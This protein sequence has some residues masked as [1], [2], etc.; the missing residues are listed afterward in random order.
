MVLPEI[1]PDDVVLEFC[2]PVVGVSGCAIG[3]VATAPAVLSDRVPEVVPGV[4]VD[5]ELPLRVV[6]RLPEVVPD[7]EPLMVSAPLVVPL[8][9]DRSV[10]ALC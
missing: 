3:G 7:A 8:V 2:E 5:V 4:I 6:L 10:V 1:V 9:E